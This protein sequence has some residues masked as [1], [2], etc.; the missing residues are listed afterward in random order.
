MR[1]NEIVD[2]L[3]YNNPVDPDEDFGTLEY[4]EP[5]VVVTNLPVAVGSLRTQSKLLQNQD[6]QWE[7]RF[8]IQHKIWELKNL[9]VDAVRFH[10]DGRIMDIYWDNTTGTDQTISYKVEW[11]DVRRS[12]EEGVVWQ[13]S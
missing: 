10:S 1:Y 9:R 11:R 4:E 6:L 12:Q 8:L 7:D 3:Q 13:G 2:L 5:T